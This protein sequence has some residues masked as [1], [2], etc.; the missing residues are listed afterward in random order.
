M[1]SSPSSHPAP[2]TGATLREILAFDDGGT[3]RLLL[4]PAGQDIGVR[5]VAFGDEDTGG[6][7]G[8]RIVLAV[9]PSAGAPGAAAA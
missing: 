5:G 1:S 9:G 6:P 7:A 4:A 2:A 3:L 8:A